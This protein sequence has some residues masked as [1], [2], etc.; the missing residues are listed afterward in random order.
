ML[1][2]VTLERL[3]ILGNVYTKHSKIQKHLIFMTILT[4]LK[5]L[6][7]HSSCILTWWELNC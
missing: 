3:K 2:L 6:Q 7:L 4:M 5:D 1:L